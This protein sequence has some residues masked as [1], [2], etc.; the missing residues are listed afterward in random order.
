[1]SLKN[2]ALLVHACDRYEFL[3]EGFKIFFDQNIKNDIEANFYFATECKQVSLANFANVL[4]GEGEWSDRLS[5]ILREEI[6][7]EYVMYMQEDMWL[8]KPLNSKLLNSIFEF[9]IDKKADCIK[10]HSS[11]VY[12]TIP[13][14]IYFEG[15]NLSTLN[16]QQ[17]KYLMSH[18]ITIWKKTFLLQ[19]LRANEN[20]WR[21][22]RRAT[23]RLKKLNPLIYQIDLFAENGKPPI[24]S[25]H[26]LNLRSEYFTVSV[27]STL[28]ENITKIFDIFPKKTEHQTYFEKLKYHYKNQL[29]HD[30]KEK[31]RKEDIF[32]KIKK[33]FKKIKL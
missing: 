7:E 17:S 30:G 33:W 2:I 32:Q 10:L 8:S 26:D 14:N 22:E 31:P 11:E 6:R 16:N 29:T 28:G 24:N 15:L 3:F 27:N 18:Q 21:N 5:K 9:A 20:P 19:Q 12:T 23:K 13:T 1:M 25:N 4:S